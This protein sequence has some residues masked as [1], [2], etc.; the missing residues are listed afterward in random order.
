MATQKRLVRLMYGGELF[1][2]GEDI[3]KADPKSDL[4]RLDQL[5]YKCPPGIDADYYLCGDAKMF[6]YILSYL[7]CK[8]AGIETPRCLPSNV[9]EVLKLSMECRILNLF[10]LIQMI[11]PLLNRYYNLVEGNNDYESI[12]LRFV[13]CNGL[14]GTF[15]NERYYC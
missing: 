12:Y 6:P 4:C 7:R 13:I 11:S 14:K 8:K 3:L 10:G 15:T 5:T 1:I 2:V 9:N